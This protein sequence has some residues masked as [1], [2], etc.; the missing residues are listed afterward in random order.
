MTDGKNC[1]LVPPDDAAALGAAIGRIRSDS[2]LARELGHAARETAVEHFGLDKTGAG[3]VS[4]AR[5]GL[6]I[7]SERNEAGS[8]RRRPEIA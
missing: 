4:L 2:T 8:A 6:S 7:W 3:T 5:L 1:I